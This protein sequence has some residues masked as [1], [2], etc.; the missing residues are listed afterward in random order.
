MKLDADSLR[1]RFLPPRQLPQGRRLRHSPPPG[2]LPTRRCYRK[3]LRRRRRW[4]YPPFHPR[5]N[6]H[7]A[8]F[9]VGISLARE[10]G[11][12]VTKP[13][14]SGGA[15][16]RREHPLLLIFFLLGTNLSPPF[17]QTPL[18]EL[19]RRLPYKLE[20]VK[21]PLRE[22]PA[23]ILLFAQLRSW[24][25]QTVKGAIGVAGKTEFNV[26]FPSTPAFSH[27]GKS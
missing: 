14:G 16:Y 20:D 26:R 8:R 5:G 11:I 15:G 23:L 13:E 2:R 10:L 27:D 12:L 21:S 9:P 19:A 7:P 6:R 4:T 1:R 18:P 17:S 24:S 22:D 3:N 25:L